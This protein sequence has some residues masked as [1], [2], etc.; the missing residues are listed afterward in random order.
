M[1]APMLKLYL[2]AQTSHKRQML[3]D[4]R[5]LGLVQVVEAPKPVHSADSEAL[6][7]Q[8][9]SYQKI[10]SALGDYVDKKHPVEQVKLSDEAFA[11]WVEATMAD[12]AR[13]KSL[14]ELIGSDQRE[15][16]RISPWGAF[17]LDALKEL[18]GE[19]FTLSFYTIGAKELES[20]DPS[21]SYILLDDV[22]GQKAIA[23]VNNT[24]PIP[25]A[26]RF[27]LPSKDL[28][29]LKAEVA[30][31]SK[32]LEE[33][34]ARLKAGLAHSGQLKHR[35]KVN[36]Q[37]RVF[38][39][40]SDEMG[41]DD[42]LCFLTG[43]LPKEQENVFASA[44]KANG[45]GY[46]LEEPEDDDNPPT[47]L[48]YP[49]GFSLMQPIYNILG[50]YPGYR[51]RDISVPF[52][53]FFLIFFAMI[54]GDGG[55]GLIFLLAGLALLKKQ[56]RR[57]DTNMLVIV[58]GAATVV[59]GALTGTWFGSEWILTHVPGLK[60]LVIPWI[61]NLPQVFDV[62]ATTAQNWVMDFCFILG[63]LQL[64]LACVMN[65]IYKIPRKNLSWVSD[66]A[67]F[68]DLVLLYQLILTMLLGNLH[69]RT[70]PTMTILKVVAV[71]Y[72]VVLVFR[73]QEPGKK[74]S[75]GVKDGLMGFLP[76]FLD[77][78]S[79]FSNIMS[80][81]RLFAVGMAGFAI[82]QSF[83]SMAGGMLGIR[84][85]GIIA[86][87]LIALLGHGLNIVMCLLSV[88]VHGIRLNILEFSNQLGMEWSGY[89]Y[90]PFR[91]T[92]KNEK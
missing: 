62:D 71:N 67:W 90:D 32:E 19:G 74:F 41:G 26:T 34:E 58:L 88:I 39:K 87:L 82:S 14:S 10:D 78:I 16:E 30:S 70:L 89:K 64:S 80:Y 52:L 37:A 59:W 84:G 46:A 31:A 86:F 76:T 49:K 65:V 91:V 17:R 20:L 27:D 7:R 56:G 81:I 48:K 22:Q 47:L 69:I 83:N 36:E 45:W 38:Q 54:I 9:D 6:A 61:A 73:N 63:T 79:C 29:T 85:I 8:A 43:Y 44:A 11:S 1:I 42:T 72:V 66:V 13:K 4:L 92:V 2:V 15:I 51:E 12:L 18:E 53:L 23:L 3:R 33:V 5:A 25:S 28:D 60:S 57:T 75:D 35:E 77:T 68:V 40:T 55:Y 21:V 50:T 24:K